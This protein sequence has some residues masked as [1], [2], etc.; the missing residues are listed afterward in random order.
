MREARVTLP[1]LVLVAGTRAAAG[2]GREPRLEQPRV[3][4][5]CQQAVPAARKASQNPPEHT[6]MPRRRGFSHTKRSGL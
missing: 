3:R 4:G 2:I 6:K 1:E 5:D